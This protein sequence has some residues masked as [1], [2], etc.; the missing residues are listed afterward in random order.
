MDSPLSI[1]DQM[2]VINKGQKIVCPFCGSVMLIA[3]RQI[4]HQETLSSEMFEKIEFRGDIK[5][6]L[7]CPYDGNYF[8]LSVDGRGRLHTERGWE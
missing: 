2:K 5:G 4:R 3:K 1:G 8:G 6:A 7:E